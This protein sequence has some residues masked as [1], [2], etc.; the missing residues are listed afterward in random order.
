[1]AKFYFTFGQIH[2]HEINGKIFDK[3]CVAEIEAENHEEAR[4]IAHEAFDGRFCFSY[5]RLSDVKVT[6]YYPRGVIKLNGP[7]TDT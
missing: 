2:R 3:D 7:K 6:E 4:G 5:A 1:M